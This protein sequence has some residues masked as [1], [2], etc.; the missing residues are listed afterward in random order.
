MDPWL[1]VLVAYLVGSVSFAGLVARARG[2]DIRAH[3]SGNPGATNVGRV[4]GRPWGA[5]VLLLDVLK[6]LVPAL[7]L[8]GP[9]WTIGPGPDDPSGKVSI[10]TAVV[11]G[12]CFPMTSGLRGGKGVATLLGAQYA[13]DPLL[14]LGATL[15]HLV[16]RKGLGYVALASV[17]LAWTFPLAQWV[18]WGASGALGDRFTGGPA[19]MLL[20]ALLVTARHAGNFRRMRAGS[21]DRYD[22]PSP[23]ARPEA[24]S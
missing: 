18:I 11:L 13:L 1:A 22:D 21:E 9:A 16:V 6:G 23:P 14:A 10:A 2:V 8:P 19:A 24:T 20:L 7:L 15:V 4:L 3:G 17:A 5:L 12:H